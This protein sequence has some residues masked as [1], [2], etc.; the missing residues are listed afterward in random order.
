MEHLPFQ[1]NALRESPKPTAA[2]HVLSWVASAPELSYNKGKGLGLEASGR[3]SKEQMNDF[4]RNRSQ[5]SGL[6]PISEFHKQSAES[7]WKMDPSGLKICIKSTKSGNTGYKWRGLRMFWSTV[8]VETLTAQTCL[9]G[10]NCTVLHCASNHCAVLCV[11]SP[12]PSQAFLA[13]ALSDQV[14]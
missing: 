5:Y 11:A 1:Q 13:Q 14:E 12:C 3:I 4:L 9:R 2:L 10:F 7:E 8:L 6:K